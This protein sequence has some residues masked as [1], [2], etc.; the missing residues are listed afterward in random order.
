MSKRQHNNFFHSARFVGIVLVLAVLLLVLIARM[1]YLTVID[2]SFLAKQGDIR[3]IHYVNIPA[4]RGMIVDRN[5]NPLAISVPVDSIW[6]NPKIFPDEQKLIF[7]L[8]GLLKINPATISKL[9]MANKNK[10]F[11][12]LKRNVP[13]DLA[14]QVQMLAIPGVYF[15]AS[16]QRFYSQANILA[17]VL[18]F[19]GV[20]NQGQE[21]LELKYNNQ[22]KGTV[23]REKVIR[24]RHGHT[25]AILDVEKKPESG[26]NLVLSIDQRIQYLTYRVLKETVNKFKADYGSIVVLDPRNGEI[27]AMANFPSFNP[28][29]RRG[30]ETS[31]YRNR[32]VT[33]MFEPG[34]TMKTFSIASALAS[35]NYTPD[36]IVDTGNGSYKIGPNTIH[37][38][39]DNG[40]IDVTKILQVSSN[41]GAAKLT[42]SL[43]PENLL[44]L[45]HQVGF[46]Q[47][48]ALA[49]PG[50][51]P[52]YVP[53]DHQHWRPIDLATLAFGYGVMTTTLQLADAYAVIADDGL[54]CPVTLL[55]RDQSPECKRVMN[56]KTATAMKTM[57]ASVLQPGGT[58]TLANI[59]DYT[60]VGK[61]GTAYIA[62][63]DGKGYD[64]KSYTSSFVG[65][66]PASNPRLVVAVV[67]RRPHGQHF[68]ALVAAPAFAKI[69]LGALQILNIPPDKMPSK[70]NKVSS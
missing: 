13:L 37:D 63:A 8:A 36:S 15:E 30:K 40:V 41:I 55:K 67:I 7:Q 22:L 12:Y 11:V 66:A 17:P 31:N 59:P 49:F 21:G 18:G 1:V 56:A 34:S 46:G 2:R 61:T 25:V 39:S 24:D 60:V 27:L 6:I 43:P 52:G 53:P 20:D 33:D 32:A 5:N 19:T 58:G 23:G 69:M 3:A 62:K 70:S 44:N 9:L 29:D 28:N 14:K 16:Y 50:E 45:Y 38:D 10:Q 68:G 48:T 4:Y 51:A 35:G 26:K 64:R 57:L 54:R 65:I 47:K 42:L